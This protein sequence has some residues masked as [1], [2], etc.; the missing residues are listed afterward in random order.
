MKAAIPGV[1]V[2]GPV[3]IAKAELDRLTD[4]LRSEQARML[5]LEASLVEAIA[6]DRAQL[7]AA[8]RRRDETEPGDAAQARVR[9]DTV[10]CVRRR[11]ALGV[12][13]ADAGSELRA[14]VDRA[15]PAWRSA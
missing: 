11:A 13:V 1:A 12:A 6:E 14:A 5:A 4:D 2:P 9:A 7:A 8:L 15:R 3:A 10:A